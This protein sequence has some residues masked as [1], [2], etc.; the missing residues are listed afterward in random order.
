MDYLNTGFLQIVQA[1][2]EFYPALDN[3]K[4]NFKDAQE[5]VQWRAKQ[6]S[7]FSF[8]FLYSQNLSRFYLQLEDD[9]IA[10]PN[11]MVAIKDFVKS[12]KIP[13]AVLEFSEL[14][15]IGKFFK[16]E[17]LR[18]LAQ[19]MMTFYDEQPI[20]WLIRYYRLAMAQSREILRKP[21]LFQHVGLTS[22]FDT[23]KLNKLQDR[24]FDSGEKR[25]KGDDPPGTV[26]TN[27]KPYDTYTPDLAY[28]SGSGYFWAKDAKRGDAFYIIFES[29]EKLKRVV[30]ETGH[31]KH[32]DDIIRNGILEASPKVLK[33]DGYKVTCADW[34]TIG[35]F[36]QGR[37]DADHLDK[38]LG[39]RSTR[40]LKITITQGQSEWVLIH[41]VAVF[42]R[43]L[44]KEPIKNV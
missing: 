28:G 41:Q 11:F 37:V 18:K 23:S 29:D 25:W 24:Y 31:E 38:K 13:W 19:F 3:L 40:C 20:D 12:Q 10:A 17:D 7:D 15:F 32:P 8:M 5:R 4:Q 16:C 33:M 6:V 44:E 14:G 22:S 21:T 42:V 27:M 9:V 36:Q 39:G 26:A 2:K 30:V 35:D 1:S 43:K 34:R